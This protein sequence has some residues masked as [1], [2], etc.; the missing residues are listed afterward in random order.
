MAINLPEEIITLD[1]EGVDFDDREAVKILILKLLNIIESQAQ[2]I[3]ELQN[4]NQSLKDEINRLKGEK[5]KP[6]F[7]PKTAEKEDDI[8]SP[9]VERKKNWRKTAKKPRIKIDRME[10]RRVDRKNLPPDAEH[11]GYRSVVVQNIK[12]TTDN[13]EYKLERFYSPSEKK[14]YEAKLPEDAHGEFK[15]ELKAFIVYLYY[16]CRVTENKIKKILEESG[17]IISEGEISNILTL[18]KKEELTKEKEEILEVGLECSNYFHT[19]DTGLK[20]KGKN[21]HIHVIC[22]E[23]FSAFF[24]TP[25]KDRNTIKSILGLEKDEKTDKIMIS[26]DARQ[27]LGI[28]VYHAL[29]WIHEIR[30]Y[31][32][33]NPLID[34]H[35]IQLREFLARIWAFYDRLD[36]SRENPEDEE[37]KKLKNEFDELFS[38]KTGYEELDKRIALTKGKKEELLLVLRFPEILLHNNPAELALREPVV[39]RKISNG[40]RS[41]D[42][43]AAWENM[44]SV[45][46]TC[47]K[48]GV[49]FFDYIKDIFSGKHAMTKLAHLISRNA[50]LKPTFY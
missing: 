30:L 5:G 3:G 9:K 2:L 23:L 10:F 14:L 43:K 13:V 17:I 25:K 32:K 28:A 1:P 19:D 8:P 29:C 12:F 46:D 27:F 31:R 39:K 15:D 35:R 36:K 48:Q 33:L 47:R 24:I 22:N 50:S 21:H 20:H 40:T 41:E 34:Y 11:K 45:Q 38:T 18:E 4:E 49:N 7:L 44:M 16:A 37:K 26:D 42:G 6:K